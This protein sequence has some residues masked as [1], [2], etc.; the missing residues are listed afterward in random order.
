MEKELKDVSQASIAQ[1]LAADYFC[2]Y[3]VN[4]ET[5]RFVEYSGSEE[6]DR[7]GLEEE[8]IEYAREDK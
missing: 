8:Y 7:L 3:Y 6:Y 2:I 1:A 5:D 4:T